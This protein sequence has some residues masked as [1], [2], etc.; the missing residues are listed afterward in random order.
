MG[1]PIFWC[2]QVGLQLGF[3]RATLETDSGTLVAIDF[4]NKTGWTEVIGTEDHI[5]IRS[6]E[7][8]LVSSP[9]LDMEILYESGILYFNAGVPLSLVSV[10]LDS[11]N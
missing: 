6:E 4:Y 2:K 1:L 7:L 5:F 8:S 9:V 3:E 11:W 10:S